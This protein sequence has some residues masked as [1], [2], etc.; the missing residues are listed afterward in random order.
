MSNL[1]N[2]IKV[3]EL[4]S[5]NESGQIKNN[6]SFLNY[7]EFTEPMP[8]LSIQYLS[9]N[10]K[11]A[12]GLEENIYQ[13]SVFKEF[14]NKK[15]G[16]QFPYLEEDEKG[17]EE[18]KEFIEWTKFKNFYNPF[19]KNNP[20]KK[21]SLATEI[22]TLSAGISAYLA[23]KFVE[24]ETSKYFFAGA[25]ATFA[26]ITPCVI[27]LMRQAIKRSAKD[28]AKELTNKLIPY[29]NFIENINNASNI[30]IKYVP[31]AGELVNNSQKVKD[32][33]DYEKLDT[34]LR[35]I[36]VGVA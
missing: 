24:L 36:Y 19:K 29:K 18:K 12:K 30:E 7:E 26:F 25:L 4:I 10:E 20:F 33:I 28:A 14:L 16:E 22:V 2:K 11:R 32:I 17:L 8:R 34:K 9:N 21:I 6:I 15:L 5:L 1:N 35:E 13:D 27:D 31:E 3:A 23:Y